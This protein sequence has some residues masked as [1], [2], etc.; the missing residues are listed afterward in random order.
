MPLGQTSALAASWMSR[1]IPYLQASLGSADSQFCECTACFKHLSI[2][3]QVGPSEAVGWFL[4]V[5]SKSKPK[6]EELSRLHVWFKE[7]SCRPG[8]RRTADSMYLHVRAFC[9]IK[10][11]GALKS[12]LRGI[13]K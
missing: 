11:G 6:I 3:A 1:S 5:D 2:E 7:L 13:A 10:I 9:P 8:N 4:N 12:F